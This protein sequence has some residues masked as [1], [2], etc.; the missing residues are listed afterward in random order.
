[1]T[2]FVFML[3]EW[4]GLVSCAFGRDNSDRFA[5]VAVSQ[6]SVVSLSIVPCG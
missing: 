6:S 4:L 1:M 3:V 5:A 2:T